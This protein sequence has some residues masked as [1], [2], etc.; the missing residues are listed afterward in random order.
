M[1]VKCCARLCRRM[2][3]H[4]TR[5]TRTKTLFVRKMCRAW[6][7][8]DARKTVGQSQPLLP[9]TEHT[10]RRM[11]DQLRQRPMPKGTPSQ[12]IRHVF[13]QLDRAM[14]RILRSFLR[15]AKSE[16]KNKV[17]QRSEAATER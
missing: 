4:G 17:P 12:N 13:P 14:L 9:K 10:M 2:I 5:I 6:G 1:K 8:P 7:K 11:A 16:S 3:E 15:V